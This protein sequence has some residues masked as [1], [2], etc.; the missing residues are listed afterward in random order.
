[1]VCRAG[2]ENDPVERMRHSC[3]HVMADAV[4]KLFPEAKITIGPVI[5][6]G[7]YYDFDFPRGFTHDDLKKIEKKMAEIIKKD[8]PFERKEVT[9]A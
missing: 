6:D 9:K 5:E 8:H 7:F 4:Q 1:M 2:H 3:A